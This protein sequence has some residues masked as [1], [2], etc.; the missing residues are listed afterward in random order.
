MTPT[1]A[2]IVKRETEIAAF[3]PVLFYTVALALPGFHASFC[4]GPVYRPAGRSVPLP[5]P[6]HRHRPVSPEDETQAKNVMEACAA[7]EAST[8]KTVERKEKTTA[9]SH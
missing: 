9:G 4:T 8:V 6:R 7:A 1:L 3:Q 2:L 5:G